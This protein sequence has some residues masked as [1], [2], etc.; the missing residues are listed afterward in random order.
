MP[1]RDEVQA[2][3]NAAW[4]DAAERFGGLVLLDALRIY[5]WDFTGQRNEPR[6]R[7]MF[8]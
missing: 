2:H 4:L 7:Q 6:S 8:C 5:L 3:V 1:S